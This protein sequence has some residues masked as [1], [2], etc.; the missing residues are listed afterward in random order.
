M[1]YHKWKRQMCLTFYAN[2]FGLLRFT[3][4]DYWRVKLYLLPKGIRDATK[5][6]APDA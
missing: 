4:A 5:P 2:K 3:L 1:K 6:R